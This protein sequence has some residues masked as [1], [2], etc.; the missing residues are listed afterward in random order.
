MQT[1]FRQALRGILGKSGSVYS[2]SETKL[3][4]ISEETAK[5]LDK[6]FTIEEILDAIKLASPGKSPELDGFTVRLRNANTLVNKK[7]V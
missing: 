5:D 2:I 1:L 3:R 6:P 7:V 4:E